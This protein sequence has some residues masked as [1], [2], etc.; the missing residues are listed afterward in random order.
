MASY[1]PA[2]FG[3]QKHCGSGDR[4]ILLC[5]VIS[6]NQ[7]TKDSLRKESLKVNHHLPSLQAIDNVVVVI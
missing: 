3:V 2:M 6:Q 1:H 5:H 4:I 7:V